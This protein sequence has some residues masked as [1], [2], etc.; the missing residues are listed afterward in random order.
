MDGGT[1][2]ENIVA[3]APYFFQDFHAAQPGKPEFQPEAP[4]DLGQQG[5]SF[6]KELAGAIELEFQKILKWFGNAAL[7][8]H[9][10]GHSEVLHVFLGQVNSVSGK[11]D[12]NIL[13]EIG[14]LKG[15]A[16]GIGVLKD[17]FF[18]I[19]KEMENES[20][21]RIGRIPAIGQKVIKGSVVVDIDI[22]FEG[23]QQVF[24]E[25]Y[26]ECD[27]QC[28]FLFFS[29]SSLPLPYLR[30]ASLLFYVSLPVP[31]QWAWCWFRQEPVAGLMI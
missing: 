6:A 11:V 28:L 10:F 9:G 23:C 19:A 7:L 5:K 14:K 1:V 18:S 27:E 26:G 17:S 12:G 31:L 21:H 8:Q 13:P 2:L 15:C 22:G 25:L 29:P 20:A 24:Q 16:D 30:W 4:S 3:I